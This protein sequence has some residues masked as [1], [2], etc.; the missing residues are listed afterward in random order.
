MDP[1]VRAESL[2]CSCLTFFRHETVITD[3]NGTILVNLVPPPVQ[4]PSWCAS[5]THVDQLVS[6]C[7]FALRDA[8]SGTARSSKDGSIPRGPHD[9]FNIGVS[10]GG[11]QTVSRCDIYL[12]CLLIVVQ[13]PANLVHSPSEN[14]LVQ[15][16]LAES[17]FQR[18]AQI[19][20]GTLH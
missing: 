10:F 20:N 18:V 19:A 13:L 12:S 9:A 4:D 8:R 11:G 7:Q 14:A 3:E 15:A 5:K 1:F 2:S 17:D 16:M 6:D